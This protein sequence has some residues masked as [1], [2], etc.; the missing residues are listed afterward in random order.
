MPSTTNIIQN[1]LHANSECVHV[2]ANNAKPPLQL[3][4]PLKTQP[5]KAFDIEPIWYHDDVVFI[6]IP[7]TL[8]RH[9]VQMQYVT[10]FQPFCLCLL[11]HTS[12]L[13]SRDIWV[14]GCSCNRTLTLTER[15]LCRSNCAIPVRK[16]F[17]QL[18]V[19]CCDFC[20]LRVRT[21]HYGRAR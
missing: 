5:P 7:I 6:S 3:H 1:P 9:Q 13:V 2:R 14:R 20:I 16:Y 15:A 8:K 17:L 19:Q 18:L 10:F 12:L 21:P 4:Q 11:L